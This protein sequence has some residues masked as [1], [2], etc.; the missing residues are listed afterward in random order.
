MECSERIL[1]LYDIYRD[2]EAIVTEKFT[3]LKV[4]QVSM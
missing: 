2:L 1:Q 4:E 3:A